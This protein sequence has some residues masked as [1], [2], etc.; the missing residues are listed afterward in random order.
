MILALEKKDGNADSVGKIKEF[1]DKVES[2]LAFICH[3]LINVVEKNL[4]P[5]TSAND[6]KVFY[7]KMV[8]DYWR[9]LAE[10][11]SDDAKKTA[12]TSCEAA[13]QKAQDLAK[14]MPATNSLRLG[15]ALNLSV[16]YFELLGDP[17]KACDTAQQAFDEGSDALATLDEASR[18]ESSKIIALL[19]DNLMRWADAGL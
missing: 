18:R 2:E 13:Y 8:G 16:F 17:D 19:R 6:A 7:L 15:I 1:R 3:D 14:Q 11:A 10:F 4:L 9:Y 12:T 5:I